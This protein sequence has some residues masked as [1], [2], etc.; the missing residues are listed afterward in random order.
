M[1][2][3]GLARPVAVATHLYP[4]PQA[5]AAHRPAE[6]QAKPTI[7]DALDQTAANGNDASRAVARP[8]TPPASR[9]SSTA[10]N[11]LMSF[12]SRARTGSVTPSGNRSVDKHGAGALA[13]DSLPSGTK[14]LNNLL[15]SYSFDRIP[16]NRLFP[17]STLLLVGILSFLLGSLVRSLLSPADFVLYAPPPG[18]GSPE[19]DDHWREIRR[20]VEWRGAWLGDD[21]VVAVVK[22]DTHNA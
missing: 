8:A 3:R 6:P 11:P 7:A 15:A 21:L 17:L 9:R 5:P 2:P 16:R 22:R 14:L 1:T 12:F 4:D 19:A 13:S 10:Q 20:L 18:S